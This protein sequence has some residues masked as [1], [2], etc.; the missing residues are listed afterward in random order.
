LEV[1]RIHQFE[2]KFQS[3]SVVARDKKTHETFVFVKG[4]PEKLHTA[5]TVQLPRFAE[6]VRELSLEGFRSI[7][8]SGKRVTAEE[9]L[10]YDR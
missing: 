4:A 1:L 3:M 9:A 7:A 2:S 6:T 5:S 10:L 8:V